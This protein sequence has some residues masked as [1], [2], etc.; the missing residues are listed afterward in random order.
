ML[1]VVNGVCCQV[2]VSATDR[3]TVQW[4]PADRSVSE[5]DRETSAVR[6]TWPTRS[7]IN[8]IIYTRIW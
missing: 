4:C 6:R 2:E 7:A 3:S 1:S 8:K 5:Y